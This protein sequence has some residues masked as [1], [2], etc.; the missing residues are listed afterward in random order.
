[1]FKRD[2]DSTGSWEINVIMKIIDQGKVAH[3]AP[4]VG[5]GSEAITTVHADEPKT[6]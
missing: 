4:L 2:H 6:V 5:T 1:M 3:I